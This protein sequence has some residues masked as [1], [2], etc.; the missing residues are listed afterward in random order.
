MH[1]TPKY[2]LIQL[3]LVH[4]QWSSIT[5]CAL[6]LL[7]LLTVSGC[8]ERNSPQQPSGPK[9]VKTSCG[10]EMVSIPAGQFAMGD[11]EGAIDTKPEHQVKVDA[12]LMD[13]SEVTQEVYQRV[14]GTKSFSA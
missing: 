11:N 3:S 8:G 9:T 14:M 2:F 1:L 13:N 4:R 10:M 5:S 7:T 6:G 12:F